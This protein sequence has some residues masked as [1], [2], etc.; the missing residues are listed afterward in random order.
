MGHCSKKGSAGFTLVE[1]LSVI[2][3]LAILMA[4][5]VPSYRSVTTSSRVSTEVNA[6]LGDLQFARSQALKQGQP[7]TVCVSV[8]GATCSSSTLW[9][10]GWIVFSDPNANGTVDS[11]ETVWRVQRALSGGDELKEPNGLKAITFNRAGFALNLPNAGV[12]LS[13]RDKDKKPNFTRC[14][15]ITTA[16]MMTTQ[17]HAK[18]PSTCT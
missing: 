9:Q 11:G 15:S 14:L 6:L 18:E 3:I 17:T 7:V 8:G 4:I 10:G 2:S 16:G 1:A 5:G 13:V 12:M